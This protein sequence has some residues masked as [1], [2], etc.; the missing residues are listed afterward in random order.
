MTYRLLHPAQDRGLSWSSERYECTV[1]HREGYGYDGKPYRWY[2]SCARG[3]SPCAWCGRM[4]PVLKDGTARVHT[5]CPDRPEDALLIRAIGA[6][7]RLDTR[8]SVLG[9]IRPAGRQLIDQLGRRG[10]GP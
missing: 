7:V 2:E 10:E 6:T 4:L 3:H 8:L 5:R 9:P 1:C